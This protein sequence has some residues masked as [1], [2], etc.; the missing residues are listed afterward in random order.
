MLILL[1]FIIL[2]LYPRLEVEAGASHRYQKISLYS[3]AGGSLCTV[4]T[5][6]YELLQISKIKRKG[7]T[8]SEWAVRRAK[9][10]DEVNARLLTLLHAVTQVRHLK[11]GHSFAP[12]P[13][14]A[15]T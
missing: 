13:L 6:C 2:W 5:E 11:F 4:T 3:W 10:V 9:A 12:R 15:Q 7:E 8:D 14:N 1:S